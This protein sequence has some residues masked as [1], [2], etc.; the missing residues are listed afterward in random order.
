RYHLV[1]SKA[2]KTLLVPNAANDSYLEAIN[3]IISSEKIDFI[4]PQTDIEVRV[5][6]ENREK[7]SAKVLLPS[8][9]TVRVCQDKLKTVNVLKKAGVPVPETIEIRGEEDIYRA[10][11]ELE[12][13]IW[14]R[15]TTG[16]GG[17][18]STPVSSV[19]AA[20]AWV[21][22]WMSRD[23]KLKFIAQEYLPGRNLAFHALFRNG[24]LITSMAR[25]RVE[26]IY[27][28]ISPSGITGT[29]SVQRTIHSE[30][31]NRIAEEAVLAIDP[32]YNGIASV[33]LKEDSEKTPRITEINAGRTFTT[34][35]FFSYAGE[36]LYR[37]LSMPVSW[38]ANIPYLY[39]KVAYEE[40]IPCLKKYDVLP[41]E[42]YWI[43]HI[44]VPAKILVGNEILS[45]MYTLNINQ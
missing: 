27:P 2:D 1:M 35:Y 14:I 18:G 38:F 30:K 45:E 19:K 16:A 6:S 20:L 11:E 28:N 32:S 10:F 5:I 13:P 31:V 39:I 41:P 37:K 17:K 29:P 25:E 3:E 40:E 33:D 22:Y 42:I 44:D 15:S 9:R 7:I 12:K 26:Y 36:L 8:K 43:R 23:K 4:H 24:E 21:E 34:S